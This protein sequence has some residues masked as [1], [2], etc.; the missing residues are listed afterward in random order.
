MISPVEKSVTTLAAWCHKVESEGLGDYLF[1]DLIPEGAFIL[2]SGQ[3]K[4]TNKTY[5]ALAMALSLASG[6]EYAMLRP[7]RKANVLYVLEEGAKEGTYY[8][9]KGL[10]RGAEISE[11][12]FDNIHWLFHA[13]LKIGDQA[14]IKGLIKY[15]KDYNIELVILDS[16][17]AMLAG[18]DESSQA[19]MSKVVDGIRAIKKAGPSVVVITHLEKARAMKRNLDI[20]DQVRGSSIL[21]NAYDVHFGA[22][23]YSM[24]Q[25]TID[26]EV[27][28]R[29]DDSSNYS[30]R[31]TFEKKIQ[32]TSRGPQKKLWRA[33]LLHNEI[34]EDDEEITDA[35][36]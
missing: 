5:L 30:L 14:W 6:T 10:A 33:T 1:E 18:L 17:F 4:K 15:V 22:R 8:R 35:E 25:R 29:D 36:S 16:L 31:W 32:E 9:V 28:H 24:K 19:E 26:L 3:Q 13:G 20:D 34:L 12:Y 23:R 27:R 2:L 21:I 11:D 7:T